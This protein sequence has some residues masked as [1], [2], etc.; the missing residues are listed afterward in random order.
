[1]IGTAETAVDGRRG[2]ERHEP[3]RAPVGEDDRLGAGTRPHDH[4]RYAVDDHR[5]RPRAD[6]GVRRDR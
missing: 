1:V 4:Q 6:I 5:H 2:G 3:V